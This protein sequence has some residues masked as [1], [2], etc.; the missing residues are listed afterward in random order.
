MPT[1]R[2]LARVAQALH[3]RQLD[4]VVAL[5]GV[6]DPHNLSAI[7]RS[8]DATGISR[9]VWRPD[10]DDP[11]QPN[12]EVAMGSERWVSLEAVSDLGTSLARLK[13]EGFAIAATHLASNAIDFRQVDWTRRWVVVLGNEH[14]GCTDA[15]LRLT[16]ANVVL[17]MM[18][19]V[20]SLNVSVAAAVLF[21]EIQRQ[22]EAAGLYRQTLPPDAV[23]ELYAR[24]GLDLDGI[25]FEDVRLPPA[26]LPPTPEGHQDGRSRGLGEEKSP[27]G[28]RRRGDGRPG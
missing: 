2:R 22:R 23:G 21:Y 17:P 4:I 14:R 26:D 9:V 11:D 5:D 20:Q 27:S 15:I 6:H 10:V 16:D 8:A 3:R 19:F 12:P 13:G 18:G 24:W 25:E 28:T 1:D 7:L